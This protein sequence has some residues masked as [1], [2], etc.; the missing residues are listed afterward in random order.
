MAH[1]PSTYIICDRDQAFT[2]GQQY[3]AARANEVRQL[4]SGHS[5]LLSV[6]EALADLIIEAA[7][8]TA[9]H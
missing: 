9:K 6:P 5:P 2:E 3:F 4:P 8:A 1:G 7:S